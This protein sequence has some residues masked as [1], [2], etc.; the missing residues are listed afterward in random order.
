MARKG[1]VKGDS[2]I[3]KSGR[4]PGSLNKIGA[5]L[6]SDIIEFLT[7]NF[8]TIKDDFASLKSPRD[9]IK[10]F[11]DLLQYGLP[12][13]QAIELTDDIDK[14][15]DNQVDELYSRI[16][17]FFNNEHETRD[18]KSSTKGQGA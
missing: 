14:L 7:E 10:L 4:P 6:R 3:N 17:K 9:R 18:N 11:I 8:D 15:N 1:F 13:L 2:R 12:R 5:D 16:I